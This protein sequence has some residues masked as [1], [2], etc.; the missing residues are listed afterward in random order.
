MLGEEKKSIINVN[1][2]KYPKQ[3]QHPVADLKMELLAK[4]VND[5]KLWTTFAKKHHCRCAI[6]S[7]FASDYNKSNVSYEQ[8]KSYITIFRNGG[9]YYLAEILLAQSQP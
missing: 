5:L 2:K 6:G 1:L 3:I 7:E 8:Q 9:S 4:I